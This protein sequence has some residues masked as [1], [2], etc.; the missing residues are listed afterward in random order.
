ML[1]KY[2][3]HARPHSHVNTRE[4]KCR[5]ASA[6]CQNSMAGEWQKQASDPGGQAPAPSPLATTLTPLLLLSSS[7]PQL[8]ATTLGLRT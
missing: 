1:T 8:P 5:D 6:T 7:L 2:L 4:N 3:L